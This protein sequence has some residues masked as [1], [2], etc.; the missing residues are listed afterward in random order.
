[1]VLTDDDKA[2]RP[3]EFLRVNEHYGDQ[4]LRKEF[5]TKNGHLED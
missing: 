5:L 1:M 3:I 2:T 4:R